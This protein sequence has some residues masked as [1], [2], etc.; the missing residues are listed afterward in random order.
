[1][2]K[3]TSNVNDLP[4]PPSMPSL[5]LYHDKESRAPVIPT[6]AETPLDSNRLADDQE[7]GL[8]MTAHP[9]VTPVVNAQNKP[10]RCS[11]PF[12]DVY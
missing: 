8:H 12:M 3:G 7:A 11:T 10:G 9:P 4:S 2:L 6:I 5:Q 1:M